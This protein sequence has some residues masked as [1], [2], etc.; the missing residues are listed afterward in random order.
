VHNAS[1]TLFPA[2]LPLVPCPPYFLSLSCSYQPVFVYSAPVTIMAASLLTLTGLITESRSLFG[3]PGERHGA[4]G[5]LLSRHLAP[6]VVYLGT[7]P[8]IIG[9]QGFNTGEDVPCGLF[10]PVDPKDGRLLIRFMCVS[11]GEA[12]WSSTC[13]TGVMRMCMLHQAGM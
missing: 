12:S 8:G 13:S 11:S 2:F 5:W 7:V 4:F 10:W 3:A 6:V 9:H 1:R